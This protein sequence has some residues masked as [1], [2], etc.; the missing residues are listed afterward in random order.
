M[1]GTTNNAVGQQIPVHAA[2]VPRSVHGWRSES[3][4]ENQTVALAGRVTTQLYLFTPDDDWGSGD[5]VDVPGKGLFDVIG[6]PEDTR[7]GPFPM[8]TGMIPGFRV[9]LRRVTNG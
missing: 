3:T 4:V 8:D 5:R 6:N 7:N 9:R 1:T 2:P